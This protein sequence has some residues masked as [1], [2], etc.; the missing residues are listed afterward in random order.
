MHSWIQFHEF[1]AGFRS[2]APVI[3]EVFYIPFREGV[4]PLRW[5]SVYHDASTFTTQQNKTQH[6]TLENV[7]ALQCL[8]E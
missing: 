6:A 5:L 2:W 7:I 3:I 8:W 1:T 4:G